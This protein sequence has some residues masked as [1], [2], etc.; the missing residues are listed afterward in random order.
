M[1]GILAASPA[2]DRQFEQTVRPFVAK[3]CLGCHSGQSA[4]AQF[5]LKAYKYLR[6]AREVADHMVLSPYAI[7]FS[8][9]SMLAESDREKYAIQRIIKFYTR[10]PTNYADYFRAAWTYRHRAALG[11]PAATLASIAADEK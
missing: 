2:L 9:H 10:Q 1:A 3:Y 5:D 11:K 7:D 6:A 8:A 4:A